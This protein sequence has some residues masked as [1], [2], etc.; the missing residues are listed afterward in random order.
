MAQEKM[1]DFMLT[2][3]YYAQAEKELEVRH[4]VHISIEYKNHAGE[5]VRLFCY[6]LPREVYERRKWVIRW[7]EA[8]LICQHPK[9]NI[10]LYHSYYDKRLGNDPKLTAD[11]RKLIAAKAQVTKMQ[12]HI[13]EYVSYQ[14]E[15]NIFFDEKTDVELLKAYEKLSTKIANVQDAETRLRAKINQIQNQKK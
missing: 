7:R 2:A 1:D 12:S 8:K 13:V 4:W 14:R 3:K 6:D 9:D 10:T 11:L 5:T 15:N